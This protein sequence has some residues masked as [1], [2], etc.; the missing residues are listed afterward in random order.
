MFVLPSLTTNEVSLERKLKLPPTDELGGKVGDDFVPSE[1][2][3]L[4][5]VV[6]EEAMVGCLSVEGEDN[7]R[8]LGDRVV[9]GEGDGRRRRRDLDDVTNVVDVGDDVELRVNN[10]IEM[11][12]VFQNIA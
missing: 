2:V 9:V 6:D 7:F 11:W 3:V 12:S 4:H 10:E 1:T 8:V 5:E